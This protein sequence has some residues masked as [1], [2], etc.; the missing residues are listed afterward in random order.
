MLLLR[1]KDNGQLGKSLSEL[2]SLPEIGPLPPELPLGDAQGWTNGRAFGPTCL[3]LTP[4]RI[5][6]TA[7]RSAFATIRCCTWLEDRTC[8]EYFEHLEFWPVLGA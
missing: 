2:L 5:I 8:E 4:L 7:S 6:S 1:L 3:C